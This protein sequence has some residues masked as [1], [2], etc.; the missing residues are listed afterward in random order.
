MC[1]GLFL[2]IRGLR[3][4]PHSPQRSARKTELV[5]I[6][7]TYIYTHTPDGDDSVTRKREVAARQAATAQ[8]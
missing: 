2:P 8:H 3:S 1:A 4:N 7:N 5:I 6:V